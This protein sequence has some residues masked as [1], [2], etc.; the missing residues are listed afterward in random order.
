MSAKA[1][2]R[3]ER[4]YLG[5]DSFADYVNYNFDHN[6]DVVQVVCFSP[7]P[8]RLFQLE[9]FLK[10]IIRGVD[11]HLFPYVLVNYSEDSL[12]YDKTDDDINAF[13]IVSDAD[14]VDEIYNALKSPEGRQYLTPNTQIYKTTFDRNN[15]RD[16]IFDD[17]YPGVDGSDLYDFNNFHMCG[18]CRK[19]NQIDFST[20]SKRRKRDEE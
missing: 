11:E 2:G 5:I 17:Y 20:P 4:G 9:E 7:N 14:C 10:T 12:G 3:S 18:G 6:T 19:L 16:F 13:A 8:R 1:P 15:F